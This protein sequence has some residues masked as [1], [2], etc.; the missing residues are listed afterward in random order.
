MPS[1]LFFQMI[2]KIHEV[3][4]LKNCAKIVLKLSSGRVIIKVYLFGITLGGTM[5]EFKDIDISDRPLFEKYYDF[6]LLSIY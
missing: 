2:G 4:S 6:F 5:I 1:F 3:Y